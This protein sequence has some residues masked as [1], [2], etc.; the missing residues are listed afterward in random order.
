MYDKALALL[1]HG[2][3][4]VSF[5]RYDVMSSATSYPRWPARAR[6]NAS[7]SKLDLSVIL[8]LC[9]RKD[10]LNVTKLFKTYKILIR[11]SAIKI[12]I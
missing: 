3:Y 5:S 2:K 8:S 1:F 12:K 4:S 10:S 11:K 9:V 7:S 6:L